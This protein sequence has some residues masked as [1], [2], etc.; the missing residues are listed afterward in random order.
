MKKIF[1]LLST[2][3]ALGLYSCSDNFLVVES[4]GSIL[5]SNYYNSADR[6]YSGLVAAYDPLQWFDYF[7]QYNS[8]NMVSDI[9][10]DD[11]YTG[12]SNE[13]DQPILVKAHFYTATSTDVPN[14]IWTTAYSGVNRSNIVIAKAP[15]IEMEEALKAK[16][17]AEAKIL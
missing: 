9:M 8:L 3:F 11:I 10:A 15:E 1:L 7:Y 6:L 17:V 12:G 4:K 2:V 14:M 5:E 16:Y 13:G